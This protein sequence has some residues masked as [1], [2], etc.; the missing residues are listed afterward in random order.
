MIT[1]AIPNEINSLIIEPLTQLYSPEWNIMKRDLEKFKNEEILKNSKNY[2]EMLAKNRDWLLNL[3]EKYKLK[4][5][6]NKNYPDQHKI[7]FREYHRIIR[8]IALEALNSNYF[9]DPEMIDSIHDI[10]IESDDRRGY[11]YAIKYYHFDESIMDGMEKIERVISRD[12]RISPLKTSTGYHQ[13]GFP[14]WKNFNYSFSEKDNWYLRFNID[15][16][17]N[18]PEIPHNN[19]YIIAFFVENKT[20]KN[21]WKDGPTDVVNSIKKIIEEI[22][23]FD[24]L[25]LI[26]DYNLSD[27]LHETINKFSKMS[28]NYIEDDKIRNELKKRFIDIRRLKSQEYYLYCLMLMGSII[29]QLLKTHYNISTGTE[30]LINMAKG[31]DIIS[32]SDKA[33]LLFINSTRNY[34]HIQEYINSRDDIT[35]NKFNLSFQVFNEVLEKL[36]NLF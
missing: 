29:E 19:I 32:N 23:H 25:E 33:Q 11:Y 20:P 6:L 35:E 30:N 21:F 10:F 27:D 34:I 13:E 16:I 7:Y 26:N 8:L 28:F 9:H 2:F 3:E 17:E 4:E 12:M 15:F 24:N 31:A 22:S 36:K 18:D 14:K 1:L 5:Y